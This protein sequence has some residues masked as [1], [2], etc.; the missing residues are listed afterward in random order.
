MKIK[1]QKEKKSKIKKKKKKVKG[2]E[3]VKTPWVKRGKMFFAV[4]ELLKI[5]YCLDK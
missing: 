5:I 1:K 4:E 3:R 2:N